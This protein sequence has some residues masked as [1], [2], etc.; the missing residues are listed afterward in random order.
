[1][2]SPASYDYIVKS[3]IS[4][5]YRSAQVVSQAQCHA[6]PDW[7]FWGS[8]WSIA[9]AVWG[10]IKG[11]R[12]QAD[13]NMG[14]GVRGGHSRMTNKPGAVTLQHQHKTNGLEGKPAFIS[15]NRKNMSYFGWVTTLNTTIN[16]WKWR[17]G[18]VPVCEVY[19]VRFMHLWVIA[20]IMCSLMQ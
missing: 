2:K 17:R 7:N 16:M 11:Q 5:D 8:G 12:S 6:H 20:L 4:C 18:R 15:L 9:M 19:L 3:L 13:G 1:M 14:E 10:V